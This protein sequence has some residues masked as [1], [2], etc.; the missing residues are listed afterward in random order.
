MFLDLM[1]VML[2]L[3]REDGSDVMLKCKMDVLKSFAKC[4]GVPFF[5]WRYQFW[6]KN[7]GSARKKGSR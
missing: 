6:G 7:V 5:H 1:F 3:I 2:I 4:G